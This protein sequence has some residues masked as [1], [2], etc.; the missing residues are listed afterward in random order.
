MPIRDLP[1]LPLVPRTRSPKIACDRSSD[2]RDNS[3]DHVVALVS[4]GSDHW[5][6]NSKLLVLSASDVDHI[7]HT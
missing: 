5:S 2:L 3:A 7:V 4:L 1:R 6:I